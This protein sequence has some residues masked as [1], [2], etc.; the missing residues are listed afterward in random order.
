VSRPLSSQRLAGA[1]AVVTGASRGLGRLLSQALAESGAAVGLMA[2]SA[3]ELTAVVR[4]IKQAGGSAVAATGDASQ[5]ADV[6]RA[7]GH[8][9]GRLGPIDL[10]VNNAGIAGPSGS[11]WELSPDA[12]W[13]TVQ[14]NLGSAYLCSRA[15]LPEMVARGNGRIVNITSKAGAQRWPQQTAYAVSKAAIIKLTEN[16]AAE[17]SSSGVCVFSVDPGLLPIG[18]SAAAIAGTAAPGSAEAR[19]DAWVR[20]QLAAGRGAE[21]DRAARLVTRIAAGDADPLSGC[22]L[23]V[24]DNLDQMLAVA[25]CMQDTD[26]Y[27]LRRTQPAGSAPGA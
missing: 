10:L 2:R 14:V 6:E 21:P 25:A 12:W 20:R 18:L 11:T 17:T 4:E 23:S 27:R 26:C 7:I 5:P 13:E 1:V 15:A 3:D 8:I 19:R 9:R 24:H 16:V 22:H